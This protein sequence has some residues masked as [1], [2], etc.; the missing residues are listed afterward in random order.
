MATGH[1]PGERD[2]KADLCPQQYFDQ[3]V[4]HGA[5]GRDTH[6]VAEGSCPSLTTQQGAVVG[7]DQN[8]LRSGERGPTLL[9][10]SHFWE[11]F[12]A[13]TTS[14]SPERVVYA[15]GVGAHGYRENYEAL[16][17]LT[18]ADLTPG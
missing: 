5:G 2:D 7:N 6:Q 10:D 13:S 9:E 3:S 15:R 11:R 14:G 16:S 8:T 17:E 12:S 4:L 18:M 1:E